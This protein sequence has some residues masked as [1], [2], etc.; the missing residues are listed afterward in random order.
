MVSLI[1]TSCLI[2]RTGVDSTSPRFVT[3]RNNQNDALAYVRQRHYPD[4]SIWIPANNWVLSGNYRVPTRRR[5]TL[6]YVERMLRV[7]PE[8]CENYMGRETKT[9]DISDTVLIHGLD[10]EDSA[11]GEVS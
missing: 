7:Y 5:P 4:W 11:D 9:E 6:E 8:L 1:H 2:F 10:E 3:V